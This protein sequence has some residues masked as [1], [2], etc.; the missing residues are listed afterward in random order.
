MN[1]DE[2]AGRTGDPLQVGISNE[3]PHEV[4]VNIPLPPDCVD[5]SGWHHITFN[6]DQAEGFALL[7]FKHAARVRATQFMKEEVNAKRKA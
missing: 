2:L 7:L 4:V 1:Y 3:Y 5:D 6:A